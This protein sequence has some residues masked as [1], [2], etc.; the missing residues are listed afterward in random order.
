MYYI[1]CSQTCL[2]Y[3]TFFFLYNQSLGDGD[4]S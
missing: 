2:A 4:E 1:V 3:V